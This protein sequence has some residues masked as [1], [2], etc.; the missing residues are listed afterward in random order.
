[1]SDPLIEEIKIIMFR[2]TSSW[3]FVP[4]STCE[5]NSIFLEIEHAGNMGDSCPWT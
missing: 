3:E 4:Q 5:K 2:E 1:M